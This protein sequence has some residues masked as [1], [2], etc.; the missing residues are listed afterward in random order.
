MAIKSEFV[1]FVR[2]TL[3]IPLVGVAPPDELLPD[4]IERMTFVLKTFS[5]GTPLAAGADSVLQPG[6]FLSGA[7][8]VIVTGTPGYMGMLRSYEECRE[9]LLGKAEPSHVNVRFL[10]HTAEQNANVCEFFAER[11]FQCAPVVGIQFPIKL[12]ASRCGVGYY[13]KNSIIQHPGYGS[14]IRLSAFITDAELS[15][16]DPLVE[17]CGGCELC[18][19][20]C[21]TGALF[22]PY[23]CDVTRCLD[24]HLG[25]N[26]KNIPVAIREKSGNLL[27]EGCTVCRDVCPNNQKLEPIAGF[28]SAENLLYPRL[29]KIMDISDDEWENGF[30][31][32]LMGFF[33]MD[34]RYLKRNAVLGLGNFKDQRALDVLESVLASGEDEV[35]GYAAWAIGRIGGTRAVHVLESSLR[36]GENGLIIQEIELALAAAR[37]PQR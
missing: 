7:Q 13:G 16:D 21:P 11:G 17:D 29:L 27:G 31:T 25:H 36:R 28:E 30:A 22:A 32:T 20:A 6:D 10:Q 14:W 24:F 2:G 8:S 4:E 18:L 9:E 5:E 33:L 34:K 26:K 37:C 23:R 19:E 12:M 35:R 3:G 1:S 15:P